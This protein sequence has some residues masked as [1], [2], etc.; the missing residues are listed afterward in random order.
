MKHIDTKF[1]SG[2]RYRRTTEMF[3]QSNYKNRFL[4]Q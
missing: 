4:S 1:I 2:A 3:T